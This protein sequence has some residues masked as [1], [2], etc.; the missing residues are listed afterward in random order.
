MNSPFFIPILARE[1]FLNLRLNLIITGKL[2]E[3]F[4]D[5][6]IFCTNHLF[7]FFLSLDQTLLLVLNSRQFHCVLQ[8]LNEKSSSDLKLQ[9][10]DIILIRAAKFRNIN[11]LLINF[12]LNLVL[13]L[14]FQ[15]RSPF[16]QVFR[17]LN[18]CD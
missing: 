16:L 17:D 1:G 3:N 14:G 8:R 13:K 5:S 12:A 18:S 9:F 7:N 4:Y 10:I 11:G 6:F 2:F 15:I